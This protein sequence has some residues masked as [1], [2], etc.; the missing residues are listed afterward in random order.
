MKNK[1]TL[2]GLVVIV[3]LLCLSIGYAAITRDL[4]I[5]GTLSTDEFG[6]GNLSVTFGPESDFNVV[7]ESKMDSLENVYAT[8]TRN[9]EN[10]D[11]VL[12]I[13]AGGFKYVNSTS[14][15]YFS[16]PIIN[17]SYSDFNANLTWDYTLSGGKINGVALG[18]EGDD[19]RASDYFQVFGSFG[20]KNE[21]MPDATGNPTTGTDDYTILL[22][23][24]TVYFNFTIDLKKAPIGQLT[25]VN[26][27]IV[28]KATASSEKGAA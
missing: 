12:D 17:D 16:V 2:L 19:R 9:A 26:L 6:S 11:L 4:K 18:G 14:M 25:D 5:G 22:V 15:M 21:N 3:A 8:L 20:E 7:A 27:T 13:E 28:I 10:G 24:H 1:K 23:G